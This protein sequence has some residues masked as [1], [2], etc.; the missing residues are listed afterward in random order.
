MRPESITSFA[1]VTL[2]SF[3]A[4][5]ANAAWC[6]LDE[7]ASPAYE[8]PIDLATVED[9]PNKDIACGHIVS[10]NGCVVRMVADI[11]RYH[12]CIVLGRGVTLDG[13]G[14]SFECTDDSI[15]PDVPVSIG[16]TSLDGSGTTTVK[17]LTIEGCYNIGLYANAS[18]SSVA[19]DITIDFPSDCEITWVFGMP[20][21]GAN[22]GI[23]DF[24]TVTR[25][26]VLNANWTG[27]SL[28]DNNAIIEDSIVKGNAVGVEVGASVTGTK[29]MNVLLEGNVQQVDA[30]SGSYSL[31]S[32]GSVFQNPG[33]DGNC[34]PSTTVDD[35]VDFVGTR[36]TFV[37]GVIR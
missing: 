11:P 12:E 32:E 22:Q 10:G 18:F 13:L 30:G 19:E 7:N 36:V 15:C 14:N 25:T 5:P 26:K 31:D 16:S 4:T 8:S 28:N 24:T 17:N 20:V 23:V 1:L 21:T 2:V 9:L 3:V 29:I 34:G 33:T 27:I 6:Y 35:C 37:D